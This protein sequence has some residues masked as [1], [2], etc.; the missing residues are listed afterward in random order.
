MLITKIDSSVDNFKTD[1]SN[2]HLHIDP[3]TSTITAILGRTDTDELTHRVAL[4]A[5]QSISDSRFIDTKTIAQECQKAEFIHHVKQW[6]EKEDNE[7]YKTAADRIITAY[8]SKQT[9]LNLKNLSLKSLPNNFHLLAHLRILNLDDNQ[10][11]QIPEQIYALV[12]LQ[13]LR[14]AKNQL[15]SISDKIN[16]LASLQILDL[17]SNQLKQLPS[18]VSDLI[19][20]KELLL[21][22][23]RFDEVPKSITTLRHLEVLDLWNNSLSTLP[24]EIGNL[25]SLHTL[26]IYENPCSKDT[27]INFFRRYPFLLQFSCFNTSLSPEERQSIIKLNSSAELFIPETLRSSCFPQPSPPKLTHLR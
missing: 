24:I 23:N 7:T 11:T 10:F 19:N 27:T 17:R 20:L 4:E 9:S 15:C 13:T 6:A 18:S 1:P 16:Q 3:A 2:Y 12:N 14:F 22:S 26:V 5:L 21:A 8:D 25:T